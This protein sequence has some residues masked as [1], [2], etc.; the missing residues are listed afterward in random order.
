[1]SSK[2]NF[3]PALRFNWLTRLYDPVLGFTM[4]EKKIKSDLVLQAGITSGHQVLDFG[5]GTLTL[6][7]LAK[8]KHPDAIFTA[9]DVDEKVLAIAKRKQLESKQEIILKLYEGT[10]LPFADNSFDRVLS[11]LVFH[12]LTPA[13]KVSTLKEI[14]R[15]L[16]PKG[17]LHVA[18]WG[19]AKNLF[20][21]LAFYLVQLLDGFETTRDNVNGKLPAFMVDGNFHL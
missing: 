15:V 21:R 1:M 7:I 11:S 10:V 8:G 18:D 3:I 16:R 5:C 17:E 19:K 4:P 20:M 2:S 13:Q 14:Y 12:H 6:S 9:I